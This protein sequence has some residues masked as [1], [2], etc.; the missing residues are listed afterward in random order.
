VKPKIRVVD[1]PTGA[2]AEETEQLLNAP[3]EDGYYMLRLNTGWSEGIEVRAFFQLR[4]KPE[5]D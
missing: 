5:R 2:T 4:A 1:V 3:L